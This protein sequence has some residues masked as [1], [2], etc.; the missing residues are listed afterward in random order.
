MTPLHCVLL[1][2][3]VIPN[4]VVEQ[5]LVNC[6]PTDT[7]LEDNEISKYSFFRIY[8]LPFLYLCNRK[9]IVVRRREF[10]EAE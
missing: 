3:I 1:R 10:K 8:T 7:V 2:E 4:G 9:Q 5:L 6:H